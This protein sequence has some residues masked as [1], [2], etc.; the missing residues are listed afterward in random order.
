MSPYI[1]PEQRHPS[2]PP[3]PEPSTNQFRPQQ[4]PVIDSLSSS[5]TVAFNLNVSNKMLPQ[6]LISHAQQDFVPEER[7]FY[8]PLSVDHLLSLIH[9]NVFRAILVN[10][11]FLEVPFE[12]M[13]RDDIASPFN[14]GAL[15]KHL[16]PNLFPTKL[17]KEVVHHPWIDL[18][19]HPRIRDNLLSREN[20]SYDI[21]E[22]CLDLVGEGNCHKCNEARTCCKGNEDRKGWIIWS[23]PWDFAGWEVTEGFVKKW[24]WVVKGCYDIIES[25]NRWRAKRGEEPLVVEV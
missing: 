12:E 4:I 8:F 1:P 22:L 15:L 20:G 14:T 17:Q 10:I 23:D 21:D 11:T 9:Y 3:K 2:D 19:P 18:W 13:C 6:P 25:S 24:G 5:N 16:P 7:A